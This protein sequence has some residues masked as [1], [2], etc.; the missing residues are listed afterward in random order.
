[1]LKKFCQ[2]YFS[3]FT[4]SYQI[5]HYKRKI[6]TINMSYCCLLC[7]YFLILHIKTEMKFIKYIKLIGI[8]ELLYLL[9]IRDNI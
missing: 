7:T 3:N 6:E 8:K 9:L 5:H 4:I 2:L 1:M